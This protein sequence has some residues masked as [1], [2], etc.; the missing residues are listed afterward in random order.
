MTA[1]TRQP[2]SSH[3]GAKEGGEVSTQAVSHFKVCILSILSENYG[4]NYHGMKKRALNWDEKTWFR[5]PTPALRQLKM[6]SI[7]RHKTTSE[8]VKEKR[9]FIWSS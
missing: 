3:P 9:E 4:I 8:L 2:P 6:H 5:V 1:S 7:A